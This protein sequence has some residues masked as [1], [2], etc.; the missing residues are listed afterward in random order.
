[1]SRTTNSIK[2][3]QYA[4]VGQVL[5]LLVKFVSR[6]IFVR[7]LS[8]EYL[9]IDGLFTN[10]LSILSL[11]ELGIG[12]AIVYSLYKPIA[13][14][15]TEKIKSLMDLFKKTYRAIGIVIMLLGLMLTPFLQYLIKEMPDVAYIRFIFVIFVL[16]SSV[17]YFYSYKRFLIIADQKKFIA[18]LYRYAIFIVTNLLQILMLVITG[19]YILFLLVEVVATFVENLL[20]SKKADRLYP[21]LKEKNID[22]LAKTEMSTIKKNVQALIFHRIGGV[23]VLGTD[24]LLISIFIGIVAVGTYSNYLLVITSLTMIYALVFESLTASV[25]NLGITQ[26]K[27]KNTDVFELINF[28]A[29]WIYGFSAIALWNL[30]NPFIALWLGP[31]YLFEMGIVTVLVINFYLAGMRTSVRVFKDAHGLYWYDRYKP[32]VESV[33]NIFASIFLAQMLGIVGIFLGTMISTISTS[34]WVE[35]YVLYRYGLK[36]SVKTYFRDYAAYILLTIVAALPTIYV[37]WLFKEVHFFSFVARAIVCLVIPN[38][39]F[40]IIFRKNKHLMALKGITKYFIIDKVFKKKAL[41]KNK[42]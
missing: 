24:N 16:N 27:E 32:L 31:E 35:P 36:T 21:Y 34:F 26:S 8:A 41:P 7:I 2:N 37:C 33:I 29:F 14:D 20:V 25:G 6:L 19:N 12:T 40:F 3:I 11:A 18:T 28:I 42:G 23:I 15:D 10:I 9:G 39:I 22:K 5:G 4:V 30:I 13:E 38:L 1:M 17:S